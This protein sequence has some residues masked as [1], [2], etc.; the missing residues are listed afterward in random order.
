MDKNLSIINSNQV[1]SY[2]N[3]I[4]PTLKT[5]ASSALAFVL[6]RIFDSPLS[7]V[8][9]SFS[10]SISL[11]FALGA[12]TYLVSRYILNHR[13][14]TELVSKYILKYTMFL[15]MSYPLKRKLLDIVIT[16]VVGAAFN[17]LAALFVAKTQA[18]VLPAVT[19][20][21]LLGF[22]VYLIN[23]IAKTVF[24]KG[25]GMYKIKRREAKKNKTHHAINTE[26]K[27]NKNRYTGGKETDNNKL[28]LE[29][30]EKTPLWSKNFYNQFIEE[31]T[32]EK[33]SFDLKKPYIEF[34]VNIQYDKDN[35]EYRTIF[36]NYLE[37]ELEYDTRV[38][39][40]G[41]IDVTFQTFTNLAPQIVKAL[42]NQNDQASKKALEAWKFL[43]SKTY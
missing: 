34:T 6:N 26:K 13:K 20:G 21:A 18:V 36:I 14:T 37:V 1:E 28:D 8:S 38:I 33:P 31:F 42:E 16:T 2:K 11:P 40:L 12:S 23:L 43:Q 29:P 15:Q 24:S 5:F 19:V 35:T 3:Y 27:I 4:D 17:L 32:K 9:S 10:A 41:K 39:Y 7:Q 25:E 30:L 22:G